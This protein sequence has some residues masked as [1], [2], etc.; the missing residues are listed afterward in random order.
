MNNLY[1]TDWGNNRVQV[2]TTEGEFLSTFK[3]KV[4]DETLYHPLSIAIDS[5]DTVFV[6]EDGKKYVNIFNAQ[7]EYITAIDMEERFENIYGLVTNQKNQLIV[8]DRS[9]GYLKVY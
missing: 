5:N 9:Y 6:S 4:N 3:N 1:V 7:G 2:F 8:S